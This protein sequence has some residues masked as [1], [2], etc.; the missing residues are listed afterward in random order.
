MNYL[1]EEAPRTIIHRDLKSQ[2]ILLSQNYV[3]KIT[4]FGLARL[5][6]IVLYGI[7]LRFDVVISLI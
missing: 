3:L 5:V 2:N 7:V 4:D 1:H 6:C